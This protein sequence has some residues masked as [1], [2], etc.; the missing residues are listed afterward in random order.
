M[1]TA[2]R[3]L[4]SSGSSDMIKRYRQNEVRLL[5]IDMH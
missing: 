5:R 2:Y 4:F 1:G 3:V